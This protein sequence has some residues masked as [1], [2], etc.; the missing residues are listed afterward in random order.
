[1]QTKTLAIRARLA[2]MQ[3]CRTSFAWVILFFSCIF[4]T[5]CSI[6]QKPDVPNAQISAEIDWLTVE[7]KLKALENWKLIG[8]IGI[9]T[10]EDSLTAAINQWHQEGPRFAIDLSSTFFGLGAT[11]LYGTPFFLTIEEAGEKPV[12]SYRPDLLINEALGIPLPISY[13]AWWIKGIP[14]PGLPFEQNFNAN[15]LPSTLTQNQWQL[16]FSKYKIV[17]GLPL[18]GKIKLERD[19]V[20]I[21]LAIKQWTQL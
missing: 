13:L 11:K 15:G 3:N 6:L 21:I 1:M 12:S 5:G 10:P 4:Q 18:P 19:N 7:E 8:K 14:A 17:N 16:S 20:R 9:R 2:S